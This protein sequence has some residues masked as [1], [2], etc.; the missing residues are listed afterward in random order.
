MQSIS[1]GTTVTRPYEA[2]LNLQIRTAFLILAPQI[3]NNAS[4][5]PTPFGDKD[6]F[7]RFDLG[8]I[9]AGVTL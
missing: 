1:N 9:A 7:T 3:G 6:L 4:D 5:R 2:G 8:Q